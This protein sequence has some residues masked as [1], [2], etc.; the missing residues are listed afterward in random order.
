VRGGLTAALRRLVAR[1]DFDALL[2]AHG[3]PV[4]HGGHERLA[5]F[6]AAQDRLAV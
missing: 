2:F 4:A 6:V 3:E 5:A 1:E